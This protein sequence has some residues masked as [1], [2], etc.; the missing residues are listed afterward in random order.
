MIKKIGGVILDYTFYKGKDLYTDGSIEDVLLDAYKNNKQ[1][2]L[3]R[4]SKEW[5]VL[6]HV[7]DIRENLLDWYPILKNEEVL[8]IGSGCGAITGLLSRKAASVTCIELSEKRSLIN[9]Y[10]N[11]NCD[12]VKIMLGNFED[13]ELEQKY[14]YVTLIGVWEY[15]GLYISG[16][17][18]Y[19]EML[20][21][22]KKFLKPNGKIIVAIENKMGLK[23]W[24]GA[25][26]DHTGK[27]YSGLNDYI[28]DKNVRTFSKPEIIGLLQEAGIEESCFYYPVPDYKLPERIYTEKISPN[29]GDIRYYRNNYDT[30]RLYNFYA[31][32]S[33]DQICKDKMF[34]Y[35]SNSFLFVCG[36]QDE[37]CN[38]VAYSRERRENY[39][40]STSIVEKK[41]GK[42]VV[43]KALNNRAE[44]HIKRMKDNERK[45]KNVLKGIKYLEG[46]IEDGMYVVPFVD[47]VQLDTY[48]Y[49]W[50][51]DEKEF[52]KQVKFII[53]N[54]LATDDAHTVPFQYSKEFSQVFG[55]EYPQ[56]SQSL[57]VTNV[58]LNFANFKMTET[59]HVYNFD[60]E[61]IFDFTIPYEYVIW[62]A[63]E[64]LYDKYMIYLK[65][66]ISK[67][68]FL[69]EV[70][71]TE[72]NI[73][74]YEKMDK[75]FAEYVFG[76]N[77]CEQYQKNYCKQV[78]M[79][80]L[81]IN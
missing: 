61:W 42:Y 55:E 57:K 64:Q 16:Q 18:P 4:S 13:I 24:N 51:N 65:D 63:A 73:L 38:F 8:E 34:S 60:Y 66:K 79:Q 67:I 32:T 19:L 29:P 58:D 5:A 56:D 25:L 30:Y 40:I 62:R 11:Q 54:Y 22:V 21:A 37:K 23:Y 80:S 53:E 45:W 52:V 46:T 76:I 77:L 68:K 6:Y 2:E 41:G 74:V 31:A 78:I 39:R 70:G 10:R 7:S 36:E 15:S 26:E 12:N 49:Q 3:L 20:K 48:L 9:A 72:Q 69:K 81:R 27:L 44:E 75:Y 33:S 28:G 43:K 17:N 14:D 47:G 59:G 1:E 35:F 50:R 71:I